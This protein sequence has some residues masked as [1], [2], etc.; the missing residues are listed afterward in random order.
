MGLNEY[1][2]GRGTGNSLLEFLVIFPLW[3]GA[4]AA[5]F[6]LGIVSLFMKRHRLWTWSCLFLALLLP[7]LVA[8]ILGQYKLTARGLRDRILHN[9]SPDD[10]RRFARTVH[11]QLPALRANDHCID[12]LSEINTLPKDQKQRYLELRKEFTFLGQARVLED[13]NGR[14]SVLFDGNLEFIGFAVSL[15]DPQQIRSSDYLLSLPVSDDIVFF[16]LEN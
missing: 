8:S 11:E 12:A 15:D 1:W 5:V 4:L 14:V 3:L 16:T 10:L 2:I 13:E 7:V 9:Y 6:V